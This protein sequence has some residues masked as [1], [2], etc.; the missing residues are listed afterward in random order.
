M[1]LYSK[2]HRTAP[3]WAQQLTNH[4]AI[5]CLGCLNGLPGF[6]HLYLVSFSP[7]TSHELRIGYFGLCVKT[8]SRNNGNWDCSRFLKK[9][10]LDAD[11]KAIV[12]PV[13]ALQDNAIWGLPAGAAIVLSV[14]WVCFLW[15]RNKTGFW[16]RAVIWSLWVSATIGFAAALIPTVLT[17]ALRYVGPIYG[18]KTQ[19]EMNLGCV[20]TLWVAVGCHVAYVITALWYDKHVGGSYGLEV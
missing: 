1:L 12:I 9:E 17:Q 3:D 10:T 2:V 16:K 8:P 20:V 6:V 19:M 14:L 15:V 7:S 11:L 13:K 18:S 5:V 4:A